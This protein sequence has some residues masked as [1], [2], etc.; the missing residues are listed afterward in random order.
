MAMVAAATIQQGL[1]PG[2]AARRPRCRRPAQPRRP[3]RRHAL[4]LPTSPLVW[5]KANRVADQQLLA[6]LDGGT[7]TSRPTAGG[8]LAYRFR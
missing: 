7:T 8:V 6:M 5:G 3:G 1:P 4:L 2:Q